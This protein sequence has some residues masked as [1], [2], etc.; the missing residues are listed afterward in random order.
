MKAPKGWKTLRLEEVAEITGGIQKGPHRAPGAN[1]AR[2]LTVAHVQRNRIITED[3]R[4]FEVTAQELERWRLKAGDVLI[5][6][7]SLNN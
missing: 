6:E 4:Y 5:I 3:P 1:A 2:Y 7:G